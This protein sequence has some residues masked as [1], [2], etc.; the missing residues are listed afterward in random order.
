MI[1]EQNINLDFD[2]VLIDPQISKIPL[3]RKDINVL[4]D[5]ALP[6]AI[7]YMMSTGTYNIAK[8]M[9]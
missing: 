8:L 3:T 9:N 5:G 2:D 7:S 1:I 4:I 6:I